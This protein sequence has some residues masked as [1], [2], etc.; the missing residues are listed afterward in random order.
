M[1]KN[2][3]EMT[4]EERRELFPV[5]LGEYKPEWKEN[6]L[7][8]KDV[9]GQ[10][11]GEQNIVRMNHYG[12]TAIPGSIAKPTVDILVEIKDNT[13]TRSLIGNMQ[14][15]GYIYL[16]Q[17]NNPAPHMMFIKGYT[18]QGF[19]EPVFHV[20]VRFAG[21]WDELYFRDYLLIHPEVAD[22]YGRLKLDLQKKYEYDRDGYT[23]A[24]TDFI[25]RITKLAR[26]ELSAKYR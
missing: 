22:D 1:S 13:D 14:S 19:K 4:D 15:C 11:I 25:E 21:D 26:A 3:D 17:P 8:E 18:P 24:K 16:E 7:E 20:H 9:L 12:S 6:Y 2:L 10:F 5:I 23:G